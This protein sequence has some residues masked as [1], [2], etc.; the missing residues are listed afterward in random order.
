MGRGNNMRSMRVLD[1]TYNRPVLHQ[2][3]ESL[4]VGELLQSHCSHLYDEVSWLSGV[5][6]SCREAEGGLSECSLA[7][8]A[9]LSTYP[10][11][12][13]PLSPRCSHPTALNTSTDSQTTLMKPST[14]RSR[15]KNGCLGKFQKSLTL[16]IVFNR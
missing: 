8:P 4:D 10:A 6:C 2:G 1:K 16:L 5:S 9:A 15:K 12:L 13:V 14:K 3:R 7:S 11:G